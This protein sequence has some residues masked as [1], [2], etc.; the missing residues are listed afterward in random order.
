MAPS[1]LESKS[2]EQEALSIR[3]SI[4]KNTD[5]FQVIKK[6]KKAGILR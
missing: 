4:L 5:F 2:N 1:Y 6:R 3:D